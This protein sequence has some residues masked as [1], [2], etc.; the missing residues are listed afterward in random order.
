MKCSYCQERIPEK[1]YCCERAE[2]ETLRVVTDEVAR[3]LDM[4][5]EEAR[6]IGALDA[7]EALT[8]ASR[9]LR[10]ARTAA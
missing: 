8:L 4:E 9:R 2:L 10:S 6:T 3:M 7:V 1:G 5:S